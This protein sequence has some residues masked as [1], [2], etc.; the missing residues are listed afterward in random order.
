MIAMRKRPRFLLAIPR[1]KRAFSSF[2][3]RF[4]ACEAASRASSCLSKIISQYGRSSSD[5]YVP[6]E[7][8]ERGGKIVQVYRARSILQYSIFI[9]FGCFHVFAVSVVNISLPKEDQRDWDV[10]AQHSTTLASS[11]NCSAA[12][13]FSSAVAARLAVLSSRR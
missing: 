12:L 13:F 9:A 11:L 10:R 5:T 4:K 7:L 6:V 2:G 8:E 3:S 1:L